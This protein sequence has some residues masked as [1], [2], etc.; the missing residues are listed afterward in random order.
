MESTALD[1]GPAAPTRGQLRRHLAFYE[2]ALLIAG[3]VVD[4]S[5]LEPASGTSASDH[6]V[7]GLVPLAIIALGVWAYPRVRAGAGA[8]IAVALGLFGVIAGIEAGYYS[9]Q[10]GPSGDDFTGLLAV[11]AGLVLLGIGAVGLWRSPRRTP[12]PWWRQTRRPPLRAAAG[13]ALFENVFSVA[14]AYMATHVARAVVPADDLGVA[15]EDVTLTTSDGLSLEGWYVPSRNG[16]AI[17]DFAGRKGTQEQARMLIRHGYGVLLFDR[18]GEGA[19]EGDGNMFGW[20]GQRDIVAA[21]DFL[22]QRPDVE[23]GRIGGPRASGGGGGPGPDPAGGS[24][25]RP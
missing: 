13:V 12:N 2:A 23:P 24:R 5:W 15:H 22:E 14:R 9:A 3:H 19:S 6:V 21:L 4:D 7:S 16:A 11:P 10:V 18:R 20:D 17:I 8:L 25:P 1:E